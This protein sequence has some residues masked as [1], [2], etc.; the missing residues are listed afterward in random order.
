MY[1]ENRFSLFLLTSEIYNRNVDTRD[2]F[3]PDKIM[4]NHARIFIFML[5]KVYFEKYVTIKYKLFYTNYT[6]CKNVN[7]ET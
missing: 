3:S 7:F 1:V 6:E 2:T 4:F 5:T